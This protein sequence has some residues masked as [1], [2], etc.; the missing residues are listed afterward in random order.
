MQHGRRA[1]IL[2][3]IWSL[4][5]G[6]AEQVVIDLA[7]HIDRA[8]FEP[9]VCCLY[10]KGRSAPSVEK[11][12]IPV[13]AL[14][15]KSDALL[16]PALFRLIR[17]WKIDLVHTHLFH[18]NLWGRIS[19]EC[20]GVPVICSEHGMDTWRGPF[21]LTMDRCLA[22][23]SKRIIFVS[24]AV[25]Q[26]YTERNPCLKGRGCVLYNGVEIE[27]FQA[28]G[29][30]EEVRQSLGLRESH[31]VLGIVG[32]LVPE[33]SHVDFI[34]VIQSLSRELEDIVG[35]IVGE[36]EL[37]SQ[38]E[39]LVKRRGIED[40]IMFLGYRSDMP[41][42]YQ[43]MDVFVTTS[44]REGFPLSVLEAMAAGIPI[45]ATDVG[46][47]PEC[48]KDGEEGLLVPASDPMAAAQAV[49]KVLTDSALRDTLVANARRRVRAS[50]SVQAMVKNH[51]SLYREILTS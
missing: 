45:V 1:R 7:R 24:K 9:V 44:L 20:A 28:K 22:R 40:R 39:Q 26:F 31:R 35:L 3:L 46:G 51:E 47:I 14:G 12:G 34:E 19:A 30:G 11:E 25:K 2:Y 42:I 48:I 38:L 27:K 49:L 16:V 21:H 15:S 32:R 33:K 29:L 13:I 8:Q 36:G 37:L 23:V 5:L 17:S 50:F 18:A 41:R 43:A 4:D 6:G 10:D